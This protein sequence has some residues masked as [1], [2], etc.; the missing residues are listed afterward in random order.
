M[1]IEPLFLLWHAKAGKKQLC[2]AFFNIFYNFLFFFFIEI[3]VMAAYQGKTSVVFHEFSGR[4]GRYPRI[5]TQ[6]ID[7]PVHGRGLFQKLCGQIRPGHPFR[8]GGAQLFSGPEYAGAVRNHKICAVQYT[9][10]LMVLL[11]NH[12]HFCIGRGNHGRLP[13]H[14]SLFRKGQCFFHG[15]RMDADIHD[16]MGCQRY[17]LHFV[18]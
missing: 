7:R 18:L 9:G 15:H 5:S 12:N 17:I 8:E 6:E 10:Q 13:F 2:P 16:Y 1:G 4:L 3:A 11:R 14:D